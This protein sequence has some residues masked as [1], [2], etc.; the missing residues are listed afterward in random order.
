MAVG[1]WRRFGRPCGTYAIANPNPAVNCWAI[2]D[3]AIRETEADLS[4]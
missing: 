4:L 3:S 2:L 1:H